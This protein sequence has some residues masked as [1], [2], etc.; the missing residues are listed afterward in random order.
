[1]REEVYADLLFLINFSMDFLCLY[2]TARFLRRRM[3]LALITSAA[4]IGGIYSVASLFLPF[5]KLEILLCD[6][7]VCALSVRWPSTLKAR[8]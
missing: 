3:R 6:V 8:P 1:M 2:F 4:I 5:A 7:A